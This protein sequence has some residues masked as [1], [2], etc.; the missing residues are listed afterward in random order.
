MSESRMSESRMS[1]SRMNVGCG[2]SM[3]R[4]YS[5]V[6]LLISRLFASSMFASGRHAGGHFKS[7]KSII[8]I[9]KICTDW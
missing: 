2:R 6:C 7:R 5:G 4:P 3:L 9:C 1:E 8:S